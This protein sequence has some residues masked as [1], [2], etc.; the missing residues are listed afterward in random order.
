MPSM[1]NLLSKSRFVNYILYCCLFFFYSKPKSELQLI[2][3][4]DYNNAL[5][6][7][8][9]HKQ[10]FI[11]ILSEEERQI[12][13]PTVFPELVRYSE[14]RDLM[15]K[16]SLEVLYAGQE[17]DIIDFSI[18]KFQMKPS[19]IERLESYIT[20]HDSLTNF[21]YITNFVSSKKE[22]IRYE[23]LERLN[24]LEWQIKYLQ[25]F[26]VVLKHKFGD[27]FETIEDKIRFYSSAYNLGFQ[28]SENDI[29]EHTKAYTFPYGKSFGDDQ[30]SYAELAVNMYL[31]EYDN[32]FD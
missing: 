15:E 21:L 30:F 2:S 14:I 16:E 25:C 13:I 9:F 11:N 23:R 20:T 12:L 17:I 32:I 31:R 28:F 1:N 24:N 18:G 4:E 22:K 10:F 26:G 27:N 19:F 5:S 29:I 6:F 7:L 3:P 8:S